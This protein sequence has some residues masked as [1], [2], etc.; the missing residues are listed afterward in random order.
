MRLLLLAFPFNQGLPL[1]MMFLHSVLFPM[2]F[3]FS[4]TFPISSYIT[5]KYLFFGLPLFLFPGNF[6]SIILLSTYSWFLL[7]TCPYHLNLPSLIFIRNR[8]TLTVQPD[9]LVSNLIFY[10]PIANLN[11]FISATSIYST[12]FFVTATVSSPYTTAGLTTELY[13]FSFTLAG[14]LM[15]QITAYFSPSFPSCL[16]SPFY[17]P[18]TNI[19][20]FHR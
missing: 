20:F 12:C 2:S 19:T 10:R 17:L 15:S 18:L 6:I 13:T 3:S 9:V 14:N 8:S 1:R 7:M 5:S 4:P 16:H 11:I